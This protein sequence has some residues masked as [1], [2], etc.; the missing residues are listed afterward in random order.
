MRGRKSLITITLRVMLHLS[1]AECGF[2]GARIIKDIKAASSVVIGK[3]ALPN[4]VLAA[5]MAG[6][7]DKAYRILAHRAGCGLVFT[8][9]VNCDAILCRNARTFDLFDLSGEDWPVAVQI[10]GADP[11]KMSRAAQM[12]VG[13]GAAIVDL[14]MGC[15]TPKIVRNH[16]GCALMRDLPR[17]SEIIRAVVDAVSPVPVT[18]KM[19]KGWDEGELVAP[20]LARLA[21]LN[22]AAAVTVHGR[23]RNQFYSGPADWDVIRAVKQAVSIPVIGNGDICRPGDARSMLDKTGCDAVMIARGSLGNSW[24]FSRTVHYLSS[25]ELLPEPVPQQR[26]ARAREHFELAL[27][28]KGAATA[29]LQMRKQLACYLRGLPGAALRRA[30]INSARTPQEVHD[31]L[32]SYMEELEKMVS[33]N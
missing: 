25:G 14:N 12:V 29:L 24:L 31:L 4:V 32:Q 23:T 7:T 28:L 21:E 11:D 13:A 27:S 6:F 33:E 1:H 30:A 8:E 26:I 10:F 16:E 5:P 2:S 17:A 19:R 9:M 3:L 20:D 18:V 22:G 15:P